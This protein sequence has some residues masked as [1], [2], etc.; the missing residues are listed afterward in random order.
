MPATA[1]RLVLHFDVNETILLCDPAGG[2]TQEMCLNKIIAKNAYV[3]REDAG[4]RRW[5]DGSCAAPGNPAGAPKPPLHF[6]FEWPEGC[7]PF[8][9]AYRKEG[10]KF[11]E[12][13]A[14]GRCYRDVYEALEAAVR[15]TPGKEYPPALT[16]RATGSHHYLLPAFFH[17]VAALTERGADFAVVIRTFGTDC[18]EVVEAINEFAA[19]R[20]PDHPQPYPHMHVTPENTWT[21]RYGD[22]GA[23]TLS[24]A[25]GVI[26]DEAVAVAKLEAA[27]VS[28]CQDHYQHWADNGYRPG[29]GKPMWITESHVED[30]LHIFFDD[31]IK[32]LADDSIVAVRRRAGPDA[33]FE[34]VCGVG[35]LELQGKHLHRVPT[36]AAV[37]DKD[38]FLQRID[39]SLRALAPN[40]TA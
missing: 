8:Y 30:V 19:G 11:T 22:G 33:P 4:G 27:S 14:S 26:A 9:E 3:Q 21:G 23:F 37:L 7:A 28:V 25:G 36:P 5:R 12:E 40:A 15:L 1:P 10:V 6:G 32:N 31:N 29:A 2:D 16:N 20:H 39:D 38:W 13:G 35:T 24:G 18:P 34:A 17:T